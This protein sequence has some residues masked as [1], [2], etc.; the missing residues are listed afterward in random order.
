MNK[1][2]KFNIKLLIDGK[3]QLVTAA[4]TTKELA[5]ALQ[6]GQK[7]ANKFSNVING[8][9]NFQK[10][11]A[12]F[13]KGL[14]E[15][16]SGM[17]SLS[18][19][20]RNAEQAN[21]MLTTVMRQRMDA[22]D[23]DVD[24]VNRVIKA[25][26]DL[27]V[28]SS[29]V[30]KTGAQQVA[31]F[32]KERESL[33]VLIPAMNNLIAQ[34]KGVNSTTNDART[35]ANLMG[36]AM[37][38]QTGALK[39]VGISFSDAQA[40][41]MKYG[42]ESERAAMLSQI[43]TENVGN[44]NEKLANTSD[45]KIKQLQMTL[46]S[47]KVAIGEVLTSFLPYVTFAANFF[48]IASSVVTLT[49]EMKLL[50][51]ASVITAFV[52]R[53]LRAAMA[54][55]EASAM[56]AVISTRVLRVAIK[57]LLISSV[58]GAALVVLGEAL[59]WLVEKFSDASDAGNDLVDTQRELKEAE[60]E[61]RKALEQT[62]SEMNFDI[63]TLKNFRGSKQQE[64]KLVQQMN[65][66]Y[67][68]SLGYYSSVAGWYAALINNSKAY[69][70]QLKV[71][72]QMRSLANKL[73]TTNTEINNVLYNKNGTLK[74]YSKQKKAKTFITGY[75]P[76]SETFIM[77]KRYE[78]SDLEV[79]TKKYFK[80]RKARNILQAQLNALAKRAQ[81]IN[82]AIYKKTQG[83]HTQPNST[84]YSSS[85]KVERPK[86]VKRY[87]YNGG[88]KSK[89]TPTIKEKP[90]TTLA[91][92]QAEYDNIKKQLE[93]PLTAE[94]RLK[95]ETKLNNLQAKINDLTRGKLTIE[96]PVEPKYIYLG[97]D[98]DKRQSYQNAKSYI[99]KFQSDFD[100]GLIDEKEFKEA[101]NKVNKEV[102]DMGLKPIEVHFKTN[103]EKLQEDLQKAQDFAV[104][105]NL[106]IDARVK[107]FAKVQDIQDQIDTI[108]GG[109]VSIK[110]N[111]TPSYIVKGSTED[112]RISYNNAQSKAEQIQQDYKIGIIGFDEATAKIKA[113]QEQVKGLGLEPIEV[114]IEP[115]GIKEMTADIKD[116]WN[117][118]QGIGTGIKSL[119]DAINENG[120]AWQTVQGIINGVISVI[121][122][123]TGVIDTINQVTA[124]STAITKQ[125][126]QATDQD[127]AASASAAMA[128][129][130]EAL[131]EA[132]KS[133]AALPFPLNIVAIAA[134]VTAVL[135]VIS[136]IASI[137]KFE[138]GGIVKGTSTK[139]DRNIVRV[140][141][142]E[143]ILNKQQQARLFAIANNGI[144]TPTF[145]ANSI[146][147]IG[148]NKVLQMQTAQPII[149]INMD[150]K[151]RRFMDFITDYQRTAKV[152][153]KVFEV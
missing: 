48:T 136:M 58:I 73:T 141:A 104:S 125:H 113:L 112:K 55:Y 138:T 80:L 117:S 40:Q 41:V 120:N 32:L 69:C 34:Q 67:G 36:K 44:M 12:D 140:N 71:E 35:I 93:N 144:K 63:A 85:K 78:D 51:G 72:A 150:F 25:Q 88:G 42:N 11:F 148:V 77:G 133:G 22:T 114:K 8:F 143:M 70:E 92:L 130:G 107:A 53:A 95:V 1:E 124:L 97:T 82:N 16:Q 18:E 152:G 74:K 108:T 62:R 39:R 116:G 87:K 79:A 137:G 37:Q 109:N 89:P 91:Q 45:G 135:S 54:S 9:D 52:M 110:A 86:R 101:V 149:N 153:G 65:N 57:G 10:K 119:T 99:D 3:E 23:A 31:T 98:E 127:A 96:A 47:V 64:Q 26:T 33:E 17:M 28:V 103:L 4:T 68:E 75:D 121:E 126:A 30:Q 84:S 60:D 102:Q 90:K 123:I 134:G 29:T 19:A 24:K 111:I 13:S 14:N 131:G 50:K 151:A 83:H 2:I 145:A 142:G 139:G 106:T 7:E 122:G 61:S 56:S 118:I 94:V 27:G 66:K 146:P 38:G 132:A 105:D 6:E 147:N 128:K 100:I 21:T 43:V 49:K 129:G 15:I 115:L 20:Y 59:A 5:Q 81:K 46:G 76:M